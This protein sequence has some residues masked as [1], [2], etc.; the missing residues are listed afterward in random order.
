MAGGIAR[1]GTLEQSVPYR[2]EFATRKIS[3]VELPDT[4][5]IRGPHGF[6]SIHNIGLP[7][8]ISLP[9]LPGGAFGAKIFMILVSGFVIIL[10]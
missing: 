2:E 7:L 1:H 6:F 3:R 9:F 4:H 5:T 10:A 8:L